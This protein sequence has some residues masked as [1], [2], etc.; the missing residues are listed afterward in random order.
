MIL[1]VLLVASSCGADVDDDPRAPRIAVAIMTEGCLPPQQGTGAVIEG[2]LVITA[3]HVLAGAESVEVTSWRGD[4]FKAV[5]VLIDP[6]LD[7][8]VLRVAGLDVDPAPIAQGGLGVTV[9]MAVPRSA[10]RLLP[11]SLV[12][13][14]RASTTD[15][16]RS[17]E[18]VKLALQL[19]IAAQSGDSGA[20]IVNSAGEIVGIL[21]SNATAINNSF[22]LHV[23]EFRDLLDEVPEVRAARGSCSR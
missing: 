19:D 7:F 10:T 9:A 16:Y 13:V 17:H 4:T 15:I 22:A 1:A 6:D 23:V 11:A 2:N 8:A 21:I 3:G 14:V 12:R 5:P 18:V 20:P